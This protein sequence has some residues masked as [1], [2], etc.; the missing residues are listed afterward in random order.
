VEREERPARIARWGLIALFVALLAD[1]AEALVDPANSDKARKLFAAAV[2]HSDRLVISAFLLL[3]TAAIIPAAFWLTRGLTERGRIAG[4]IASVLA[5]MGALGHAGLASFYL[6]VEQTPKGG[7]NPA[8]M[9]RLIDRVSNSDAFAAAFGPLVIAF[10][11][12]LV[13]TFLAL[14]RARISPRWAIWLVLIALVVGIGEPF[15]AQASTGVALG[16][17]LIAAAGVALAGRLRRTPPA[18]PAG[19]RATA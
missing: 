2:Q 17:M 7:S 15:S 18:A 5:V 13:V 1:L 8:E 6:V 11:V 16:L 9:I 19:A 12:A 4:R 3:A 14:H 10:P